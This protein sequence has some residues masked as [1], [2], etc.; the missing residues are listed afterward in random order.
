MRKMSAIGYGVVPSE[1]PE[2]A[3]VVPPKAER[4]EAEEAGRAAWRETLAPYLE[5][6]NENGG[7]E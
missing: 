2:T 7:D 5:Y 3:P 1:R 6:A 4:S